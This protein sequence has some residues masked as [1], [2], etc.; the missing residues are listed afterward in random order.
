MKKILLFF[1]II[2]ISACQSTIEKTDEKSVISCPSLFF[3]SENNVYTQGKIDNLDLQEIDYIA[4]LNNYEF[5]SNCHLD[6]YYNNYP[7]SL[8][9]LIEP[10]NPKDSEVNLPIFVILYDKENRVIDKQYFR[11]LDE[12]EYKVETSKFQEAEI[13]SQLNISV[14]VDQEVDSLTVGFVKINK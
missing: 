12:I 10:I 7:I 13:I 3:S 9:I 5:T 2:L 6:S 4:S 11:V 1:I 14:R 8:L